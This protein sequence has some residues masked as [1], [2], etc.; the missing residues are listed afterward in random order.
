MTTKKETTGNASTSQTP[1]DGDGIPFEYIWDGVYSNFA[2]V[3]AIGDG[4][5]SQRWADQSLKK[6][7]SLLEQTHDSRSV[8]SAVVHRDNLLPFLVS[9]VSHESDQVRVLDFGGGLGFT[10][11]AVSECADPQKVL[12][13]H[14]VD[15]AKSC[16]LG[17]EL[18]KDD[19]R[20]HFQTS[21]PDDLPD[22]DIVHIESSLQYVDDWKMLL[23]KLTG[24]GAE[25]FLFTN[26][27]AGDIPTFA[28]TQQ[29]YE[30]KIPCWFFNLNEVVDEMSKLGYSLGFKSTFIHRILGEEQK[31]PQDNLPADHRLGHSCN[32]MFRRESAGSLGSK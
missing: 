7:N 26:L 27:A 5:K 15:L 32:L 17:T 21:L 29:Y 10:Y 11:V 20:V 14:I 24:F 16:E 4:F 28:T 13:Y 12:D 9:L 6:L 2:E 30:S 3:P 19:N 22:V 18:F 8:P 23:S 1:V 31:F 25:F